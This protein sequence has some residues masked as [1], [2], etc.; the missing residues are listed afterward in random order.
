MK[1]GGLAIGIDFG[2]T[3]TAIAYLDEEGKPKVIPNRR[4]ERITPSIVSFLE[5]GEVVVGKVAKS[6]LVIDPARTIKSVKRYLGSDHRFYIDGKEYSPEEIAAFILKKV[7]EDAEYY[8]GEV[9]ED[10]VITCPAYFSDIQRQAVKNAGKIA[11]LNVLRI[12]NEPTS[13]ALAF[14]LDKIK[15]EANVLVYDFGGGTFDVSILNIADGVFEVIATMGNNQLGGDDFDKRLFELIVKNFKDVEGID[16]S[17]DK[18]A[19]QKLM[20]EV[21][22]AKI[23]LSEMEST[24]IAIPFITA[25]VNG[26]KHLQITITRQQFEEVIKDIVD[27]TIEIIDR[28]LKDAGME[29]KDITH[30]L[31]IGGSSRIPYIRKRVSEYLGVEAEEGVDPEEA[32]ALGAAI[33]AGIIRGEIKGIALVDVIPLSLGVEVDGGLF[34]PII[35]RNTPVPTRASRIFTTVIDG[36]ESVEIH[37]LQGERAIASENISLGK[38]ELKGIK[39]AKKGE[40]RIEVMFDIDVDG[41]LHV[42]ARDLDTGAENVVIIKDRPGLSEEE[43][44]KIISESEKFKQKDEEFRKY[45]MLKR[46]AESLVETVTKRLMTLDGQAEKISILPEIKEVI[47]LLNEAID[48]KDINLIEKHMKDLKYLYDELIE[49]L[50]S[51]QML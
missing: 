26:P 49:E 11:G 7:K 38:F 18:V 6:R 9:I 14:G 36:Q 46:K 15:K 50:M 37:I 1:L 3:K 44:K 28:V 19:V 27:E 34:V 42:S 16:L 31:M 32:V 20:E 23:D 17:E 30:L 21:E 10:V 29:K 43:V 51:L 13:A 41:I 25:D 47:T 35:P 4:G 12:I 45:V 2:T 8:L 48:K 33:Q 40:P 5:D 22:R 39:K 24:E